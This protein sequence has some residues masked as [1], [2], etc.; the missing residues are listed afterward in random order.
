MRAKA[1]TVERMMNNINDIWFPQDDYVNAAGER[2]AKM[3]TLSS[4]LSEVEA[5]STMEFV[6]F[7]NS[8]NG[9]AYETIWKTDL[10]WLKGNAGSTFVSHYNTTFVT[11]PFHSAFSD[12]FAY[13][14]KGRKHWM[15]MSPTDALPTVRFYGH[16]YTTMKNCNHREDIRKEFM[17]L[18]ITEEDDLFYFP[19]YWAHSVKTDVG[20]TVMLNYRKFDLPGLLKRDWIV[21]LFTMF[22]MAHYMSFFSKFDPD[23]VTYIYTTGKSPKVGVHKTKFFE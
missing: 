2:S 1:D 7:D 8:L 23:E 11:T 20:N 4:F 14:C 15:M 3:K 16:V 12:S 5:G 22:G 13:M 19:P 21:G 10:S 9:N 6:A 18:V 17:K